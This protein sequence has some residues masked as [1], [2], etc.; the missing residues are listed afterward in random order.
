[1]EEIRL[2]A[3]KMHGILLHE[4]L[5]LKAMMD[6]QEVSLSQKKDIPTKTGLQP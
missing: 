4:Y 6:I 3:W 1:M 5:Q 2:D